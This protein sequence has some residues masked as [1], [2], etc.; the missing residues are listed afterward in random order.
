MYVLREAF[1]Y[2]HAEIAEIL[3][4]TESNCQQIYRRAR[5]HVADRPGRA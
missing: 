1:A 5:Q 4:I 2:P 3:D